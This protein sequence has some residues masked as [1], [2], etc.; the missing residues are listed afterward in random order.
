[1][2][3]T[4]ICN[5]PMKEKIDLVQYV[6]NDLSIP[7]SARKVRYPINAVL[8]ETASKDDEIKIVL[9]VKRDALEHYKKNLKDF[10]DEV[11]TATQISGAKV[12][13]VVLDT[14]FSEKR[15][16]HEQLMGMIVGLIEDECQILV[17]ITYG[18]KELPI[19]IFAALGFAEKFLGCEI[20]GII[21]GQANFVDGKAVNTK[22]CDMSPLYYLSSVSGSIHCNEPEKARKTLKSLL[23]L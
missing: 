12:D 2:K 19:I 10:I 20:N 21:Y 4:I 3:K 22:I 11:K 5:I 17:D 14:D 15:E 1:M 23:S 6:S 18:P 7:V 13:V 8:E 9:L 16:V